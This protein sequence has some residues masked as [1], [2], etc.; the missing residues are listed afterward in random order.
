MH[1]TP[2]KWVELYGDYLFNYAISRV[3]DKDQAYDIVQDT[4]LA[5]LKAQKNFEGRSTEKT[6]LI[7]ILKRKIIDLYR[8]NSRNKEHKLLDKNFNE[9]REAL[10]FEADGD[11]QG[12]WK[13]DKTPAD[14]Q[15]SPDSAVENEE[16]R[17]ILKNCIGLL[18][19]KWNSVFAMRV[20]EEMET[21]EVCK[22]LDITASNLW[23]IL[24]RAKHQLR[25]CVEKNW[26]LA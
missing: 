7:S 15:I 23:V 2:E 16:L 13:N 26:I 9:G 18:P 25:E 24:H 10:P 8:K 11:N 14:W 5:A 21:E 19:D 17:D 1:T 22:E 12:H 6:W 3:N 4:F 20:V